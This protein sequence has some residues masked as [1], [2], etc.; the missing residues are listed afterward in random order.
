MGT[1]ERTVLP[2]TFAVDERRIGGE[3][4][5]CEVGPAI[6]A[7]TT[8][9]AA[10][11]LSLHATYVG[12]DGLRKVLVSELVHVDP[13]GPELHPRELDAPEGMFTYRRRE[14]LYDHLQRVQDL[15]LERLG[16][17]LRV[18]GADAAARELDPLAA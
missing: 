5:G 9:C 1:V 10:L 17:H 18:H 13:P 2:I 7:L 4:L 3:T 6:A 14:P 8:N 16:V 15:A 12:H 11:G